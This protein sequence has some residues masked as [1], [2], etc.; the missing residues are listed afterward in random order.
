MPS[1]NSWKTAKNPKT[2]KSVADRGES[3]D[4][5][6]RVRTGGAGARCDGGRGRVG[7][8]REEDGQRPCRAGE[9][10]AQG[11]GRAE[12][13]GGEGSSFSKKREEA[14][15]QDRGEA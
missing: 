11:S 6:E 7:Q 3:C 2:E 12:S 8:S 13:E 10:Q 15:L 1:E 4:D 14:S 9:E 5:G